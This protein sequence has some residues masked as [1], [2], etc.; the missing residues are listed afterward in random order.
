MFN[1]LLDGIKVLELGNLVSGP[2]C[3]KILADLGAEVIKIEIPEHGDDARRNEPFL[4]DI[5]GLERSGLFLYLNM[6]KRG[7][8]LNLETATGKEIFARLLRHTNV[9]VANVCSRRMEELGIT[10]SAIRKINPGVVMTSITP[11]GL[12]GPYRHFGS[13]ELI[14][15]SMGALAYA[16]TREVGVDQEP[17]KMPAKFFSFQAGLSAAAATLGALYKQSISATGE[18]IDVSEQESIVQNLDPHLVAYRSQQ[19]IV[20]RT[21]RLSRAPFHILRCKDGYIYNAF[22][23]EKEWRKFVQVMGQPDWA[24]SELFK[25]YASRAEYWD[26]L[27]P[28]IEDWTMQ[29]SME[30]IYRMSQENGAPVGAVYTAKELLTDRQMAARG[31][32]VELE[33]Q[34]CGKLTYPGVPYVS[35]EATGA[36][37]T[38]APVLGQDNEEIY[39][40][41]LGY[42]RADL[43]KFAEAGII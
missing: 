8:T 4:N 15:V 29:F 25:D 19:Q 42:T 21:D 37:P 31:F 30:E 33:H 39:C 27:K 36:Q 13:T 43:S 16:S 18:H 32:F 20:S 5:P 23:E 17:L 10:Y 3:A 2:F 7:V 22:S 9:L 38:A 24:D 28:L 40:R 11:F 35:S 41:R 6:N 1:R 34:V 26:A 12:T 14:N